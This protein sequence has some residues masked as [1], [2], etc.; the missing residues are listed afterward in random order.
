MEAQIWEGDKKDH[1]LED[2]APF[3]E[4]LALNY[5]LDV[6]EQLSRHKDQDIATIFREKTQNMNKRQNRIKNMMSIPSNSAKTQEGGGTGANDGA[7]TN[8]NDEQG[9]VWKWMRRNRERS[10]MKE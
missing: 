5:N 10:E 8:A 1:F 9:S 2:V 7:A 4:H 6:R 3:I